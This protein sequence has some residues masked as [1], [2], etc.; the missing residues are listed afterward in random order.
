M[1]NRRTPDA[2]TIRSLLTTKTLT[3]VG[4][5]YG[6]SRQR[7]SQIVGPIGDV[8][9]ARRRSQALAAFEKIKSIASRRDLTNNDLRQVAG[10]S[11]QSL[12][13]A[14][15]AVPSRRKDRAYT[16]ESILSNIHVTDK[17]CWEWTGSRIGQSGYGRFCEHGHNGKQG[18]AHRAAYEMFRGPIPKGMHV[19]HACDNPP[20][21]NPD[22][23]WLGTAAE[24]V[25]DAQNKGRRVK[26][27]S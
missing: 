21:C 5:I 19:C 26:K 2:A 16:K 20:C 9:V 18:Y 10:M 7:I 22:H 25:K 6:V 14:G 4:R 3:E 23:L 24:N 15:I 13:S 17:N 11:I 8:A 27:I 12:R 1:H